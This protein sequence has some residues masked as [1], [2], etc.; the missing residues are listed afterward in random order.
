MDFKLEMKIINIV[1]IYIL[2][3]VTGPIEASEQRNCSRIYISKT[4]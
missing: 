1:G 3:A 2:Y 4:V